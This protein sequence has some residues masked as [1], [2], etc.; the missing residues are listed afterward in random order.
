M[1]RLQRKPLFLYPRKPVRLALDG[2]ALKLYTE[3]S[4]PRWFP[5]K[6]LDR[7]ELGKRVTLTSDVLAACARHRITVTLHNGGKPCA[8]LFSH[9]RRR[10]TFN[11]NLVDFSRLPDYRERYDNWT[12]AQTACLQR[13]AL[14]D[15]GHSIA[16]R[17]DAR[18][19]QQYCERLQHQAQPWHRR[20]LAALESQL[21][22]DLLRLGVNVQDGFIVGPGLWLAADIS[23]LVAWRLLPATL[24]AVLQSGDAPV[25][26]VIGFIRKHQREIAASV[27]A[28]IGQLDLFI[29]GENACP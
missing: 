16:R 17:L 7:I 15:A 5:L 12:R 21:A 27:T 26:G 22:D 25:P 23:R 3:E 11:Q 19:L 10:S 8:T 24:P 20:L 2:P 29:A 14:L 4:S 13:Q 18:Q 1:K 6:M 9:S 28:N